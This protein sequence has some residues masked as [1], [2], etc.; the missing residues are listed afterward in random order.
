MLNSNGNLKECINTFKFTFSFH[1]FK[2]IGSE[3]SEDTP[4]VTPDVREL[5][6]SPQ[7]NKFSTRYDDIYPG[8]V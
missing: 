4:I 7:C 3:K 8:Y 5:L 1:G 6:R 2:I